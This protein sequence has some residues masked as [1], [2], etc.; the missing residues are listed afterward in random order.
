MCADGYR[1]TYAQL[2]PEEYIERVIA[3]FYNPERVRA[4]VLNPQGWD[5]WLVAVE[6]ERVVGAG[7]GGLT[8]PGVAELFVLYLGPARRG[9]G[10]GTMLL[11][12]ITEEARR[13]GAREQWVS[14]TRDNQKAIPFYKARGF[15][16]R[17]EQPTYGAD[18]SEGIISLRMSRPI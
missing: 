3:E 4:E 6:G 17:G 15:V 9:E 10:I 1:A 2:L 16:E 18:P 14:V 12:A 11:E 5:G 7:G 8:A 13:Q